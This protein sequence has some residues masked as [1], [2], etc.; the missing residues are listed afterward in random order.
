M[1]SI[2]SAALLRMVTL[3][4]HVLACFAAAAGVVLGDIAIFMP[5]RVDRLLLSKAARVVGMAL[6]V[7]WVTG[8]A[9]IGIDTGFDVAVIATK[10]KVLAKLS[11]VTLL[12]LN[13]LALHRWAFPTLAA[14]QEHPER[15]AGL[16]AVLGAISAASWLF[17]AFLGVAKALVPLLSYAGF[18]GMYAAFVLLAVGFGLTV[19]RGKLSQQLLRTPEDTIYSALQDLP[20]L[21]SARLAG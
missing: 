3:Y 12:T 7:L 9:L 2:D 11:V 10:S 15:A 20:E 6:I 19:M 17:A 1:D 16:P 5:K 21:P 14:P 8:L 13:G 4:G 18:M